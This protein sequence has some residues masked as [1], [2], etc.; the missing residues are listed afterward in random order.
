M[1]RPCGGSS[2][3]LTTTLASATQ[4]R[5]PSA[6]KPS[7]PIGAVRA[8]GATLAGL[9]L[10][11]GDARGALKALQDGNLLRITPNGLVV[12]LERA[13][14]K[15]DPR[16]WAELNRLYAAVGSSS[17]PETT[18][19]KS[20]GDFAA[21]GTALE[22]YRSQPRSLVGAGPLSAYLVHYGMSECAPLVLQPALGKRPTHHN[23][24]WSLSLLLQSVVRQD[25]IGDIAGARRTFIAATPILRLAEQ[26]RYVGKLRPGA[27]RLRYVMGILETRAGKLVQARRHLEEAV[28]TEPSIEAFRMLAAIS[29]QRG[30][31]GLALASLEKV[32]TLARRS[33]DGLAEVEAQLLR[34]ELHRDS[35]DV[36]DA[37]R[38]L[39]VA[40]QKALLLRKT[41]ASPAE[42]A[43]AERL[44]ARILEHYDAPMALRR[45]TRRALAA[46]QSHPRQLAASVLDASRRGLT[47]GDIS[48]ARG[49][50]RAALDGGLSD[51]DLVYVAL[52]LRLL[53][54]DKGISGDGSVDEALTQVADSGWP[55]TLS[56][57]AQG[58]LSESE[59]VKAASTPAQKVEAKFYVALAK[60]RQAPGVMKRLTHVAG[61][62]TIDLVEVTIAR[63]LLARERRTSRPKLPAG[64]NLP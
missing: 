17:R 50:M 31:K 40:L 63:D 25:E 35:D 1:R 43:R 59:F 48:I 30:N 21:W 37:Q 10:R 29:R 24:S 57:W 36:A 18:V 2:W 61:A 52:W 44:L 23:L 3:G 4:Q 12:R 39:S 5:Q 41:S 49:A 13:A 58:R 27:A 22:L 54:I 26:P 19:D 16:A 32:S 56:A 47:L 38:S 6:T 8:G 15:N 64:L 14:E 33:R 62:T 60:G 20:L 55:G 53:E 46:A 28:K 34:F 51:E 7:K 11:H 9:Y 42:S 45:A